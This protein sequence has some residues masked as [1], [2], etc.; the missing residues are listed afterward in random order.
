MNKKNTLAITTALTLALSMTAVASADP[1]TGTVTEATYEPIQSEPIIKPELVVLFPSEDVILT[2]VAYFYNTP[3][4]V[5]IGAL[6]PQKVK[7][8]GE[9]ITVAGGEWVEIYTW[10]GKAWLFVDQT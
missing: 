3:N 5:K 9:R 7:T 8:T 2:E 6:A 4:G 1:V 10:L